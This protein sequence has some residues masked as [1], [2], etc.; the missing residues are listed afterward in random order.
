MGIQSPRSSATPSESAVSSRA[1][2]GPRRDL[3]RAQLHRGRRRAAHQVLP[4]ERVAVRTTGQLRTLY[5]G[6]NA[7][8]PGWLHRKCVALELGVLSLSPAL[9]TEISKRKK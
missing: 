9:G 7:G 5:G 4:C 8:A 3:R 1:D 2:R 6:E